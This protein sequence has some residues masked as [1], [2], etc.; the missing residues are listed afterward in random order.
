MILF[1]LVANAT[2]LF[3]FNLKHKNNKKSNLY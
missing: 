3:L 1:Q 2:F